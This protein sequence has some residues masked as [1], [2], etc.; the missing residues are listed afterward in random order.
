MHKTPTHS[1]DISPEPDLHPLYPA[2]A[3]V[4]TQI[5]SHSGLTP[6]QKAELVSHSLT[7][8]CA[9]GDHT[10]LQFLLN[11]SHA[12]AHVDLGYK[13][14]DGVGL[15]S[16]A[17]HGFGGDIDRDVEREECVRLLVSQ[18]AD[19]LA[20]KGTC[21]HPIIWPIISLTFCSWM[22]TATLC[23][24]LSTSNS[25]FISHDPWMFAV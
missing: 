8:S 4:S 10:L 14:D 21:L 16:M 2:V 23:C 11:D 17:I 19:L 5:S 15:I 22:D 20:D 3:Q 18:G 24:S 6:E 12:Q 25:C 13:D 9:F 7:R 1:I